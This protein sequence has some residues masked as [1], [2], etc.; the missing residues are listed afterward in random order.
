M[1]WRPTTPQSRR[2]RSLAAVLGTTLIFA[3]PMAGGLIARQTPVPR[4]V[5]NPALKAKADS[6]ITRTRA[7]AAQYD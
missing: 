5:A 2:V 3:A 6:L 7:G 1:P 4:V